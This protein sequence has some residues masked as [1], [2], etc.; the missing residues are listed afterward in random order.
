MIH[1]ILVKLNQLKAWRRLRLVLSNSLNQTILVL[2]GPLFS[3]TVIR[4]SSLEVWGAFVEVLV[5]VQL[6]A[7]ITSWGNK[8][9]LLRKF[10]R[11]PAGMR[12]SWQ[13]A[14]VTRLPLLLGL[15]LI[16]AIIYPTAYWPF[17]MLWAVGV[18]LSQSYNVLVVYRRDFVVAAALELL[19]LFLLVGVVFYQRHVLDLALLIAVYGVIQGLKGGLYALHYR[20][21]T[22]FGQLWAHFRQHFVPHYWRAALPFFLLTFSG[23]LNSRI[24]LYAVNFFLSPR[25]VAEY[26]VFINFMLYMQMAVGIILLPFVKS[27]YRLTYSTIFK[28]ASRLFLIGLVLIP[29]A[30]PV[31][32]LALRIMYGIVLRPTYF[33]WGILFI[34][35]IY[36][37]APLIYALFKAEKQGLVILINFLGVTISLVLNI[38]LL[39]RMGSEG[40]ILVAALVSWLAMIIYIFSLRRQMKTA[41]NNESDELTLPPTSEPLGID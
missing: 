13:D 27:I 33:L 2:F 32:Y 28:L 26:Q 24:D 17:L 4:S 15:F 10:S 41:R 12:S 31:V 16:L 37:Y 34:L 7:H 3:F 23:L 11:N 20:L 9:Y 38:I 35:P 6:G 29:L 8:E 18:F 21:E 14:F 30:M 19:T 5:V 1:N 36:Y 22:Q 25:E 40:A 39:P